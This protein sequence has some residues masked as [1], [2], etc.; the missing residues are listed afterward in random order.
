MVVS[1]CS[2]TAVM[3]VA[4]VAVA[5]A[6]A[7]VVV[8]TGVQQGLCVETVKGVLAHPLA[9]AAAA[10]VAAQVLHFRAYLALA[11][12][13]QAVNVVKR[14]HRKASASG[15]ACGPSVASVPHLSS[16]L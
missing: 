9:A 14:S 10:G 12:T 4:A 15:R 11:L 16:S 6:V 3:A 2:V 8:A 7:V 13:T 1:E 5:V